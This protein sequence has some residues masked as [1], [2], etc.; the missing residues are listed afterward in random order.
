[1]DRYRIKP[2]QKVDLDDFDPDDRSAWKD[3][4]EAALE[5]LAGLRLE[6]DHLQEILYAEHTHKI[7]VVLQA[8]D[9]AGKDGTIR[10]VFEGVNPQGVHVASFKGPTL[11]ETDHDFLWRIHAQVPGKGELVMFNRSHYEEVLVVRVHNLVP[12]KVWRGR[13]KL[14]NEFEK[15]LAETGTTI[16]KF[17]LHITPEEQKKRLLDRID[18]PEKNWK[19]SPEDLVERKLWPDYMKAYTDAL[20]ETSTD[21]AP[22]YVVPANH[23]WYRNLLVASV[24]VEKM[25]KLNMQYPPAVENITQYRSQLI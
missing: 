15:M 19:F 20:Y 21:Y 8:M 12:E 2:G 13:Y 17:F 11:V 5:K 23:N 1:M 4:K 22:W 3:G 16:L 25:K 6:L 14:I 24:I 7:L 18:T 10:S 9:T